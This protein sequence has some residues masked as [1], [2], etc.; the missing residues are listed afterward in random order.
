MSLT[1]FV[2]K[3][4]ATDLVPAIVSKT[5][6]LHN[7]STSI[8]DII[9]EIVGTNIA[10]MTMTTKTK[11]KSAKVEKTDPVYLEDFEKEYMDVPVCRH[12]F[13]R[14][15]NKGKVC[16]KPL[17]IQTV[18]GVPSKDLRCPAHVNAG[19]S[20]ALDA[21]NKKNVSAS[22]VAKRAATISKNVTAPGAPAVLKTPASKAE[23]ISKSLT[24][25]ASLK[26]R[27]KMTPK[28]DPTPVT[29]PEPEAV[30]EPAPEPEAEPEAEPA[31]EPAEEPEPEPVEEPKKDP[32]P[33][34]LPKKLS[35]PAKKESFEYNTIVLEDDTLKI[36][37][38]QNS[39]DYAFFFYNPRVIIVLNTDNTVCHGAYVS[40]TSYSYDDSIVLSSAWKDL[41]K[42]L[43]PEQKENISGF[44]LSYEKIDM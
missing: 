22:S 31:E 40:D 1:D 3:F 19:D 28:K 15:A 17:T 43:S 6:D 29:E 42:E 11:T 20:D 23:E 32:T 4:I 9:T 26:D 30:E 38:V 12:T 44:E 18:D 37:N 24:K 5:I 8:D 16:V 27:L 41:L 36:A 39:D 35:L 25:S 21:I 13:N 33:K 34:S 7:N 10:S 2:T 14:G